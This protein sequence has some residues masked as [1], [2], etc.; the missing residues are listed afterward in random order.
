MVG[1]LGTALAVA[2]VL[3]LAVQVI[4]VRI[5]TDSGRSTD[6]LIVVLLVNIAL[7]IPVALVVGYPD[8]TEP[9][10]A[11]LSFVAAGLVGTM[12]GWA[13]EYAGIERIGASRSE[14]IKASQPLHAALLAVVILGETLTPT[15]G[16]GIVLVVIGV[17]IISWES[18][19]SLEI[20]MESISW[21]VPSPAARF[22]LHCTAS[23][24]SS[25]RLLR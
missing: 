8:Y 4:C 3:F 14:P 20:G 18:R 11:I 2:A 5:G 12:L 24:R 6:A 13:F 16:V 10:D 1:F 17:A 7:L 15:D 21:S 22:S 25:P 9:P 23:S 19:D